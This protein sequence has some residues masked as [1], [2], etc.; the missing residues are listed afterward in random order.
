L[1][2]KV[3]EITK[4]MEQ[5]AMEF[6]VVIAGG[7]LSGVLTAARL[8]AS[9]P[10]AR[11]ALVEKSP[12]VG[13][14]LRSSLQ[15]AGEWGYGLSLVSDELYEY[16]QQT[17]AYYPQRT[18]DLA[19]V[20]NK[21]QQK[22]GILS[23]GKFHI[24]PQREV[25]SPQAAKILGGPQ[26]AA[27]WDALWQLL[28]DPSHS[29]TPLA[30]QGKQL[31]KNPAAT[32]L[33]QF[34]PFCGLA[35]LWQAPMGAIVSRGQ[36]AAAGGYFGPWERILGEL[37]PSSGN[38]NFRLFT[39]CQL[40]SAS[41]TDHEGWAIKTSEGFMHA[42]W[43]VVAQA[44]WEAVEWLEKDSCHPW[45]W[46]LASQS[47]PTS[48]VV[49]VEKIIGDE[50]AD[51]ATTTFV[52]SEEALVFR[53]GD[54]C[55]T[56]HTIIDFEQSLNSPTVVKAIK[57]LRRAVAKYKKA[58]PGLETTGEYLALKSVA[59][60]QT[61][62]LRGQKFEYTAEPALRQSFCGDAYGSSFLPDQNLIESVSTSALQLSEF[63]QG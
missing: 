11:V 38:E 42:R 47:K 56:A 21:R 10:E 4:K 43:L 39:S 18:M 29:A 22:L 5:L 16:I 33:T 55:I 54:G 15:V 44:P 35:D 32:V 3:K 13:G 1:R 46:S 61:G 41:R 28:S 50:S 9:F 17:L 49:L 37:L 23:G 19:E 36:A 60:P 12:Q 34:A 45:L 2:L 6:D 14:R 24:L 25:F 63:L 48:A 58:L 26:A 53:L 31:G 20:I 8:H 30:K 51:E 40:A 59:W 62:F 27:Q 7:G 52:P 57:Q